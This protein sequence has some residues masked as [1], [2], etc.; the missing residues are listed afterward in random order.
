MKESETGHAKGKAFVSIGGGLA[1]EACMAFV[2]AGG[3]CYFTSRTYSKREKIMQS[4]TRPAGSAEHS[5]DGHTKHWGFTRT[6][7]E[8][9]ST[10]TER[11]HWTDN[12]DCRNKTSIEAYFMK[13]LDDMETQNLEFVGVLV[14][15]GASK[16]PVSYHK[17]TQRS[18]ADDIANHPDY[19]NNTNVC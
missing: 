18:V 16:L 19:F 9:N 10:Q 14:A 8:V 2:R 4:V 3:H 15:P 12:M 17:D 7:T 11:I 6:W 13:I 5:T 1:I